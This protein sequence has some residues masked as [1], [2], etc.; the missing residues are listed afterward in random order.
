MSHI[1]TPHTRNAGYFVNDKEL[2]TR[3]EADIQTCSHC[4]AV[5]KM[6]EWAK[7]GAF[8]RT[9]MKP[10]CFD[11]GSRLKIYGCEPLMKRI[12]EAFDAAVKLEKYLKMIGAF[13]T[14]EPKPLIT[15]I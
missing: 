13:P 9:C 5:I 2:R 10:I 14:P 3:Q 4:D 6:Q 11:C 15:G 1:G 8:C 7:R 12:D